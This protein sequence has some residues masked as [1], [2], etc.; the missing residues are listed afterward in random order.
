MTLSI[1]KTHATVYD[2]ALYSQF[3]EQ[4]LELLFCVQ[5]FALLC[6]FIS[7]DWLNRYKVTHLLFLYRLCHDTVACI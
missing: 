5:I 4:F 7:N 3:V 2:K 6:N 1:S